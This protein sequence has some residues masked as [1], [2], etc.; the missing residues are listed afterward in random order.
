MRPPTSRGA[1]KTGYDPRGSGC[2]LGA[3]AGSFQ[4]EPP[5]Q[6]QQEQSDGYYP[7]DP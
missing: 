6:A 7:N 3:L 1:P 2:M 5:P 4:L